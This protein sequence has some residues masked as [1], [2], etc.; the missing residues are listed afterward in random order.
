MKTVASLDAADAAVLS[1]KTTLASFPW[2]GSERTFG[3]TSTE[4]VVKD[5][6]VVFGCA[7]HVLGFE[8]ETVT[9]HPHQSRVR[10]GRFE[11]WGWDVQYRGIFSSALDLAMSP[12]WARPGVGKSS[13]HFL[14]LSLS[15]FLVEWVRVPSA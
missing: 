14:S 11:V 13:Q 8:S 3:L 6:S 9:I 12:I 2:I 15:L 10:S 1:R 5:S 7:I 4:E